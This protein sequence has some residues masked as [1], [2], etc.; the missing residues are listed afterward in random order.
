M[1]APARAPR[2]APGRLPAVV[3]A[4]VRS[5]DPADGAGPGRDR[6]RSR[7]GSGTNADL[8]GLVERL[9]ELAYTRVDMVEKRGEI[10]VRGGILDVFPP[11]ADH[12][13][14]IEFWGDEVSDIR[15]FAVADQ[16]SLGAVDE[17]VA[18]RAGRSCS[19]TPVRERAAA[20]S[21]RTHRR[22]ARWREMLDNLANGISVEGMESLIPRAGRRRAGA[23]HRPGAGRR[24][25]AARR[26]GADPDPRRRPG[27]HRPGVPGRVLDGRRHRRRAPDRPRRVGLPRPGATSWTHAGTPN[28]R[29]GTLPARCCRGRDDAAAPRPCTGGRS[30]AATSPGARRPDARTPARRR[31]PRC[32]WSPAPAPRPAP[33]SGCARPTSVPAAL[34]DELPDAPAHGRGHRHLRAARRRVR[35]RGAGWR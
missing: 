24:A 3:V 29:S 26:P 4:T 33:G 12:P 35:A 1:L 23:A 10:A 6:R 17:V 21:R 25:R 27:P 7:C 22:P 13:V 32:S 11:T 15:S 30:T 2:G 16:R 34:A 19:P 31:Q 5:P 28:C 20:L 18:P 14:R 9:V 8:T